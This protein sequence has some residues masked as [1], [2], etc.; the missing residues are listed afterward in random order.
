MWWVKMGAGTR[1][2]TGLMPFAHL[3]R[4]V[5]LGL[6][7]LSTA[8]V[9][10]FLHNQIQRGGFRWNQ[11]DWLI[12]LE[13]V[14]VRRGPLGSGLIALSDA[15]GVP[16][17]T[18]VGGLQGAVMVVFLLA[19]VAALW[20]LLRDPA[21]ALV[22]F[23]P[24]VPFVFWMANP[25]AIVRKEIL[26][27]AALA[28]LLLVPMHLATRWVL[29]GASLMLYLVALAGH[30]AMV[31][32]LPAWA[33]TL[34]VVMWPERRHGAL[35]TILA[36]ATV[37]AGSKVAYAMAYPG[38][39]DVTLVCDPLVARGLPDTLCDGAIRALASGPA[40]G[41]VTRFRD[42]LPAFLLG[43]GAAALPLLY[44]AVRHPLRWRLLA[45]SV[46]LLLPILPLFGIALD[47]GRWMLL[48][49]TA[50]A[51]LLMAVHLVRPA[52]PLGGGVAQRGLAGLALVA[53]CAGNLFWAPHYVNAGLNGGAMVQLTENVPRRLGGIRRQLGLP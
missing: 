23:S 16:L 18:L 44:L 30:E 14:H 2:G 27:F 17:L 47:W 49:L 12:N 38:V 4:L 48:H 53:V 8:L 28:V 50:F 46:A 5:C 33:A 29:A 45:A 25:H 52:A 31:L 20:R 21:F 3:M 40:E 19:S 36:I 6:I 15:T 10:G 11:G 35:W 26:V 34:L 32:M 51:F 7:A 24:A 1:P 13:E 42:D 43:Y 9:L 22:V 37:A 39:A 41:T